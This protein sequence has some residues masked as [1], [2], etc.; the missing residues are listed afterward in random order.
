MKQSSLRE[1]GKGHELL[2]RLVDEESRIHKMDIVKPVRVSL[3]SD[4]KTLLLTHGGVQFAKEIDRPLQHQLGGRAW[5][6]GKGFN[7]IQRIWKNLAV[8]DRGR[9]ENDIE[10]VFKKHDLSIRYTKKPRGDR[11]IYGIISSRFVEVNQLAFRERFLSKIK[12]SGVLVPVSNGLKRTEFGGV[13]EE[14]RFDNPG[15]QTNYKYNLV[16]ARNTGYEAYRV[17][18]GREILIC[19]NGLTRWEGSQVRWKHTNEINLD[20][21]IEGT[22]ADGIKN[23]QF[24]ENRIEELKTTALHRSEVAEVLELLSL[25]R[26][27]KQRIMNRF[28]LESNSLG[29]CEW[30]FS[31]ALTWLA[32]HEKAVPRSIRPELTRLGTNI[33]ERSL[34]EILEVKPRVTPRGTYGLVLPREF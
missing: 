6:N 28:T 2:D 3:A 16:Y 23:Q 8:T 11:A 9:L 18:W 15:F 5:G 21:F 22:I 26:M 19:S 32:S 10:G 33:L 20:E 4:N 12:E 14:F 13:M 34:K 25:A 27:T 30:A 17:N 1:N 24:I 29:H 31:Q 7:E